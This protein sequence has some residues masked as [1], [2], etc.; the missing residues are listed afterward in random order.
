MSIH[1]VGSA[2]VHVDDRSNT[3]PRRT[4]PKVGRCL[5][6]CE[7]RGQ[8]P[9]HHDQLLAAAGSVENA[10]DLL[11]VAVT[12]G[13]LDYSGQELIDPSQWRQFLSAHRWP[14][15]ALAGRLFGLAED[16]ALRCACAT[17]QVSAA[18]I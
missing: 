11:D 9:W 1:A 6:G 5:E 4:A 16:I 12:W 8:A 3:R 14:D 13:E 17:G 10:V 18:C 2:E 15:R 7:F